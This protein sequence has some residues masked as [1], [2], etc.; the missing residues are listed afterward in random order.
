MAFACIRC[1]TEIDRDFKACPHCGEPITDFLREYADKPIDGKYRIIQR[2]GIGGMGEVFKVE[3]TFLGS[4]RVVK[5]IRAQIS[6]STE[7]ND[8]FLRE[9]RLA[10]KVQ[11]PN[12]A[13]LYDFSAL[14]DGSHYMVWEFIE[15]EN[16]AQLIRRTGTLSPRHAVR[17][18]IQALSGLDAIHRAGIVHRD[19]SPENL[20]ITHAADGSEFVKIIDLGVAKATESDVA[21]T[22]TGMFVGKFRYASPDHLGFLGA[23][24][25]IDGRADLYSLA[26]VLFEMVTGRPPF[27]A[28][29]PHAYIIHHSRDE[30]LSSPDLD[31]ITGSPA[32][33]SVL[34]RALDRDRN[35]RFA[36]AREFADALIAVERDLPDEAGK[37]V[38]G[39]FDPD[40]TMRT[41]R[42]RNGQTAA[43]AVIA[44][45]IAAPARTVPAPAATSAP[46]PAAPG[47]E[48][49]PTVI[50]AAGVAPATI[51]STVPSSYSPPPSTPPPPSAPAPPTIAATMPGTA[52]P[53][54]STGLIIAITFIA[55]LLFGALAALAVW[56]FWPRSTATTTSTTSTTAATTTVASAK[57]SAT[58]L[59]VTPPVLI[60]NTTAATTTTPLTS[61][62]P[63]PTTSSASSTPFVPPPTT[64]HAPK[65]K[66]VPQEEPAPVEETA[67]PEPE[68][69]PASV[70]T[71]REKGDGNANDAARA[72][73]H[74]QIAGTTRVYLSG[75]DAEMIKQLSDALRGRGVTL[76]EGAPI[77]IR[78][79]GSVN[80]HGFG[81]KSRSGNATIK[82][83]GR[84]IFQ[85]VMP[86]EDYRV[87]DSPAEAFAR[88]LADALAR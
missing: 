48:Q 35:K 17:I 76:S 88:I 71:Y 10:T 49:R 4:I 70:L 64:T 6:G 51:A 15:G 46:A 24:E 84:P 52:P 9:A 13:T 19:I 87:G 34:S 37:T 61:T 1:N 45:D 58:T 20:M 5:I 56:K 22:Q 27:E 16:L 73:L 86:R 44:T 2:L 25:H 12:V 59:D 85:Y 41:E 80:S 11:H 18:A 67:E 47:A 55:L 77:E 68:P 8:R 81:R 79:T 78:F 62:I 57:P 23:G 50:T 30:Y 39:T 74:Q 38:T 66:P 32:L 21:M 75:G 33:Q 7:A 26:I 60:D 42:T 82:K 36:T 69:A 72:S 54:S 31:R 63:P 14:P 40:A 3:H 65:P 29:S 43:A 83:N 28:T 53:R